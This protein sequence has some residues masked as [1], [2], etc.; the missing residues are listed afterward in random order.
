M[1][2]PRTIIKDRH[3]IGQCLPGCGYCKTAAPQAPVEPV[4]REGYETAA[5]HA[6]YAAGLDQGVRIGTVEPVAQPDFEL[7]DQVV[8]QRTVYDRL[9][10][11]AEANVGA[12]GE[13]VAQEPVAW[14]SVEDKMPPMDEEVLIYVPGAKF[15]SVDLD[16]WGEIREAPVSWSSA[17]IPVGEGWGN[18]EF[19]EVSHWMP[20]PQPPG[21][22]PI[23][24]PVEVPREPTDAMVMAGHRVGM[25]GRES[26][27]YIRAVW[28]DMYDTA[29]KVTRG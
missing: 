5:E 27:N 4:A 20:K 3:D 9:C 13:P 2:V 12:T 15:N 22:S 18:H 28:K 11:L 8:V 29:Q 1:N 17:T 25:K 6:A 14:I 16:T 23:S 26:F 19:E 10:A 7:T 24:L 21:A